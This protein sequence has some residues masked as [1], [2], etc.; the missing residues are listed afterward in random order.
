M[1]GAFAQCPGQSNQVFS[2][3]SNNGISNYQW[4]VPS[5]VSIV[6]G[7]GTPN[8]TVNIG[9]GFSVGQL[10]VVATSNC[11]V[12]SASRCRTISSVSP[13]TP[14]NIVGS[15]NGICDQTISYSIPAISGA[16]GYIG[17]FR[18]ALLLQLQMA[19]IQLTSPLPIYLQPDRFALLLK[20]VAV[21]V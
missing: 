5:N 15:V 20:I 21:P 6:S 2:V 3:P 11:G 16:T 19:T 13:A 7:Q 10:C 17:V 1:S 12:Q 14:A 9:A 18:Q 8:L 4:S